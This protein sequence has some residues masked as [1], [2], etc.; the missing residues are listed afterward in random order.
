VEL[1]TGSTATL[2][3]THA[4]FPVGYDGEAYL[5]HLNPHNELD[6]ALPNGKHCA[7]TFDYL[8]ASGD[9]PAIGPLRCME[10]KTK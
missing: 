4:A 1:P 9:I 5:E 2:R 3:A 7:V 10:K 8:P 6:V